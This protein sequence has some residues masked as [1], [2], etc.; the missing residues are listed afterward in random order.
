MLQYL[1]TAESSTAIDRY[2]GYEDKGSLGSGLGLAYSVMYLLSLLLAHNF[3]DAK[4]R[5]IVR[6]ALLGVCLVPLVVS[7][8]M[9]SRVSLYLNIFS[10]AA[11]PLVAS[12]IRE[13]ALQYAYIAVHIAFFSRAFFV[14][15]QDPIFVDAYTSY[16]T[17]F[18]T[19]PW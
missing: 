7:M 14:F 16:S 2:L 19:L 15:F 10:I 1:S 11:I 13:K 4:G 17:I 5:V 12:C 18:S 8:A 3:L 6:M 9:L